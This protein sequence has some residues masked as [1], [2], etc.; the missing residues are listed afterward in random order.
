MKMTYEDESHLEDI[1]HD[2]DMAREDDAVRLLKVSLAQ[3][4]SS[5]ES[6]EKR[7]REALP[8]TYPQ[9]FIDLFGEWFHEEQKVK[10]EL[11]MHGV[12][13]EQR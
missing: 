12:R 2:E 11:A 5:R 1:G 7:L 3:A 8:P 6:F 13:G 9:Q 10:R 4:Q